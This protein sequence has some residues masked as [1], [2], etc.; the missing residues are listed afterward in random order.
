[1]NVVLGVRLTLIDGV[2]LWLVV[3]ELLSVT[4]NECVCVVVD[5]SVSESESEPDNDNLSLREGDVVRV[6]EILAEGV[7]EE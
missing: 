6:G 3:I 4:H 5:E 7:A 1:M 2:L